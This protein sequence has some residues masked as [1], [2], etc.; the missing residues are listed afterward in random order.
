MSIDLLESAGAEVQHQEAALAKANEAAAF[1]MSRSET[2]D[3]VRRAVVQSA[4]D[5]LEAAFDPRVVSS[6][7]WMGTADQSITTTAIKELVRSV[8]VIHL[9][10]AVMEA[11][12]EQIKKVSSPKGGS[13]LPAGDWRGIVTRFCEERFA[14]ADGFRL[15]HADGSFL[16]YE[17]QC[18]RRSTKDEIR[19]EMAKWLDGAPMEADGE[20]TPCQPDKHDLD[21]AMDALAS[22]RYLRVI[23][24]PC[25]QEHACQ[26][27][28][29]PAIIGFRNGLLDLATFRST[30]TAVLAPATPRWLSLHCLPFDFTSSATCPGWLAFL[31]QV[32]AGDATW[33][34]ALQQWMGYCLSTDTSQQKM[35]LFVGPKRAGKGTIL[36]I[37]RELV[38]GYN[39]ASPS[40][41]DLASDFGREPLL[42]KLLALVSDAHLPR[43]GG[44]EIVEFLKRVSGEDGITI[45][46]KYEKHI[47]TKLHARFV[48]VCNEM[49]N[50]HDASGALAGRFLV[51]P[52]Q[53]SFGGSEDSGLT[54]RLETELPGIANWALSGLAA[55]RRHCVL[56]QCASGAEVIQDLV[57]LTSPVLAFT[58]DIC[59]LGPDQTIAS[60][61]LF[62]LWESWCEAENQ[63]PGTQASFGAMLTAAIPSIRKSRPGARETRAWTYHGIGAA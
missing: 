17:D 55:Y 20:V 2:I 4:R 61:Q 30:D 42:D 31:D 48:I 29:P 25:W 6:I 22:L 15:L 13:P 33:I 28:A 34:D 9:R 49:A 51:W 24:M 46:R 11:A 43:H 40:L 36:R 44:E 45:N 54:K 8:N 23:S 1:T 59:V 12:K 62:T 47:T 18:W 60:S 16:L 50:L 7:A 58:E 19:A 52:F 57:R 37:M 3:L 38:G 41:K 10:K 21:N 32:A 35:A 27:L 26:T 14:H 5:G 39:V 63:H 56:S 53:K